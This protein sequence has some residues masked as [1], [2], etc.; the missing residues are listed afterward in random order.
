MLRAVG[1][2]RK[3]HLIKFLDIKSMFLNFQKLFSLQQLYELSSKL[4]YKTPSP[5]QTQVIHKIWRYYLDWKVLG[6]E[7]WSKKLEIK[8]LDIRSVFLD[9]Q[10]LIL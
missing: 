10:N 5:V 8:L 3:Q 1:F 4:K 6:G 7:V 9:F 2:S